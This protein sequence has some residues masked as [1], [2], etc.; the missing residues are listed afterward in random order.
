VRNQTVRCRSARRGGRSPTSIAQIRPSHASFAQVRGYTRAVTG[1]LGVRAGRSVR[2]DG[3]GGGVGSRA[4]GLRRLGSASRI[5]WEALRKRALAR[6]SSAGWMRTPLPDELLGVVALPSRITCRGGSPAP[7]P[8]HLLEV[9]KPHAY[10]GSLAGSWEP[11]ASS[12]SRQVPWPEVVDSSHHLP[13]RSATL[14]TGARATGGGLMS[15]GGVLTASGS[16]EAARWR[17]RRVLVATGRVLEAAGGGLSGVGVLR[18][19]GPGSGGR[20]RGRIRRRGGRAA[21]PGGR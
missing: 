4:A 15:T 16:C 9:W 5:D 12:G 7:S 11:T 18:W 14:P 19:F 3:E 2:L 17:R 6:G 13:P 10:P 8:G 1:G 21:C 20:G